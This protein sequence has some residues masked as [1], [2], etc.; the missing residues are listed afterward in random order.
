MKLL[1]PLFLI[2][3]FLGC[4]T[5]KSKDPSILINKELLTNRQDST[6]TGIGIPLLKDSLDIKIGQM[7]IIGLAERTTISFKD[8]LLTEL[9]NNK[10]GGIVLYEKNIPKTNSKVGLKQMISALKSRS[11]IPLWVSIDEEG[12]KVH[13]LKAKYG[14]VDIPSAQ[15]LGQLNNVDST[16]FYN[17][18]LALAMAEMGINLNCAP[19]ID[20]ATNKKNPVIARLERSYS[21]DPEI[22]SKHAEACIKAHHEAKV[23]TI[24]KHFPGHGSSMEDSHLGLVDITDKWKLMEVIPFQNLIKTGLVDGVMTAHI[25]NRH[26]DTLGLPATLSKIIVQNFLRTM[27]DYK[28]VVFSDD[29]QMYAISKNYGLENAIKMSIL[30]GVDVLMFANNVNAK[31]RSTASE[32]HAIIKK[33]VLSGEIS[34]ARINE[35]FNRIMKMK[36]G[37]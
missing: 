28:G 32:I 34:T 27:L 19:D 5:S 10:F 29:M 22:V 33:L 3:L 23:K 9:R 30:A 26:L 25:V 12:G 2:L 1:A 7:I 13:R 6:Q 16:Y 24:I 36:K 37:M 17:K 35:S 20:L 8:S 31:D 11:T 14:F 21:S 15:Y 4:K 18:K